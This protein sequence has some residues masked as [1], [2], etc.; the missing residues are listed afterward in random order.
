[1]SA[2]PHASWPDATVR[3]WR[4]ALEQRDPGDV[5]AAAKLAARETREH[6][7]PLGQFLDFVNAQERRREA[8]TPALGP[9]RMTG[10]QRRRN[11]ERLRQLMA[12]M[13]TPA[14]AGHTGPV[15]RPDLC[16]HPDCRRPTG[17][18][19]LASDEGDIW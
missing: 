17:R 8:M 7:P 16:D 9:P 5:L 10:V 12:A 3:L 6:P 19:P 11:L 15:D 1:M 13:G 4:E 14:M 2:W 18:S